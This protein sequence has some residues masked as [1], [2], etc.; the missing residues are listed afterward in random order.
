MEEPCGQ[1]AACRHQEGVGVSAGGQ[2]QDDDRGYKRDH[3]QEL[4]RNLDAEYLQRE[5]ELHHSTEQIT[6]NQRSPRSP[7]GD[8]DEGDGNP[9]HGSR[10]S[11][12]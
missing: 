7:G 10:E 4:S 3:R 12:A 2:D 9:A 6:H 1:E 8:D 5:T 11:R